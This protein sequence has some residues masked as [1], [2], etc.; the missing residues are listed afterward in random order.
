MGGEMIRADLHSHTCYSHGADEPALM[1]EAALGRGL[2]LLGF[3]EHSPRPL[4]FDYSSEYR[5]RLSAHFADYV[6]EVN[7]LRGRDECRV[8]LGMEMDWIGSQEA[9]V[10]KACAAE[11]F[12]YLI[13]SVH[14]I[15][16][17]GFDGDPAAWA[18]AG[19]EQCEAWYESYFESW[20]EMLGS[21][22]FD[23]AAHPDLIKIYSVDRFHQWLNK[24][25]SLE[26]VARCLEILR[27]RNMAMEISSAGLRKPCREIYPC[28]QIMRLAADLRLRVSFASDAHSVK[29]VG[30]GFARLAGY[31]RA[32]GFKRQSVPG[33]KG[34]EEWS[35]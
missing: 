25:G 3:S 27:G 20:A 26:K 19:Q 8:L 16:K 11:N 17:W 13:G 34:W 10:R 4:G 14:F 22:L 2:A 32:F 23:I 5:E 31:A 9:F 7:E 12:D 15:G 1:Y 18:A 24:P 35:F 29:D 28:P 21:G 6:E 30:D 33:K